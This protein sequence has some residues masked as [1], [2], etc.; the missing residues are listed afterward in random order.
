MGSDPNPSGTHHMRPVLR[1]NKTNHLFCLLYNIVIIPGNVKS[2]YFL[3]EHF[4]AINLMLLRSITIIHKCIVLEYFSQ[5]LNYVIR[6]L[7]G[8]VFFAIVELLDYGSY[9][10][11]DKLNLWCCEM[12]TQ[13]NPYMVC[14]K[15]INIEDSFL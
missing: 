12:I 7:T 4:V 5:V 13:L 15:K 9:S 1:L 8:E 3:S 14:Y 11:V 2:N 6:M 10:R